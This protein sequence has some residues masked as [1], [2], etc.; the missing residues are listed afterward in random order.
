MRLLLVDDHP[1]IR[2]GLSRAL[3]T[4]FPGSSCVAVATVPEALSAVEAEAFSIVV[5]DLSLPG[6]DGFDV[7]RTLRQEGIQTPI[8]MLTAR[9]E[10]GD[11][12]AGLDAGADD[13]LTKPFAP[14]EL[15][16]RIRALL[17]RIRPISPEIGRAHV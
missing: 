1:L 11:R 10:V 15:S 7:A 5:L 16:A 4:E 6:R 12:V 2:E 3:T 17:R 13:Y 14:K 9:S 8:L